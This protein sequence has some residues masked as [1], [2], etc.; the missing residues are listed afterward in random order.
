[1]GNL[2][3][4]QYVSKYHSV[5]LKLEDLDNFQKVRVFVCGLN[6]DYKAKV[7]SQYPNN[8]E[9]AIRNAQVY[10][11]SNDKPLHAHA[12]G[13]NDGSNNT[14]KKRKTS[15]TQGH[16]GD[17]NKKSKGTKV[18]F[19]RYE[20]A[21]ARK[22]R[23]CFNFLQN[24]QRKYCSRILKGIKAR[25]KYCTQ[26]IFLRWFNVHITWLLNIAIRPHLMSVC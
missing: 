11:D 25:R 15:Y 2:I 16:K 4:T 13:K 17:T 24:H 19:S 7:K 3:L 8:L 10:D 26:C 5:I 9:Q 18:L 12:Q 21:R 23:L 22:E 6:K 20:L 14:N 1:M